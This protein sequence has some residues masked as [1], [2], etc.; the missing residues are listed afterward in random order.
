[1]FVATAAVVAAII[2]FIAGNIA[3]FAAAPLFVQYFY[4]LRTVALTHVFTLGWVSLM[5]VGVLRQLAPVPFGLELRRENFLKA[6]IA[7]WLPGIATM[8]LGLIYAWYATTA[9]ATTVILLGAI[10]F[11]WIMLDAVSRK[12]A[13]VPHTYLTAALFYFGAAAILGAWMGLAKVSICRCRRHFIAYCSRTFIWRGL[14][15]QA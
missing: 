12:R 2:F 6:V 8:V 14:G 4:D 10:V 7:A 3:V 9:A 5:I 11:V 1:M 13:D 15:G